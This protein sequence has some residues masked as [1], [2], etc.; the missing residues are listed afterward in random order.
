MQRSDIESFN[1]PLGYNELINLERINE[2]SIDMRDINVYIENNG[3]NIRVE[4]EYD[5]VDRGGSG[6]VERAEEDLLF[7]APNGYSFLNARVVRDQDSGMYRIVGEQRNITVDTQVRL[8]NDFDNKENRDPSQLQ[9]QPN[10]QANARSTHQSQP[11]LNQQLQ[12]MR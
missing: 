9:V 6:E 1:S 4:I 2:D 11:P 7:N 3:S 5:Y 10:A 12:Y 8:S